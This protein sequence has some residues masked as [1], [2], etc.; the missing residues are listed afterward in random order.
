MSTPGVTVV[1]SYNVGLFI[2]GRRFP[3]VGETVIGDKFHEG[4]GR[5]NLATG[6]RFWR[7]DITQFFQ[8]V[9]YAVL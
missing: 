3:I 1:G 6:K 9:L 7:F 5:G 8:K 4:G 2:K